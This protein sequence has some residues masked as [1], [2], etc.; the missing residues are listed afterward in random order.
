[1][2]QETAVPTEKKKLEQNLSCLYCSTLQPMLLLLGA[3]SGDVSFLDLRK[4]ASHGNTTPVYSTEVQAGAVFCCFLSLFVQGC[5]F[6]LFFLLLFLFVFAI[7][8]LLFFNIFILVYLFYIQMLS[9]PVSA[10]THFSTSFNSAQVV[11]VGNERGVVTWYISQP[12]QKTYSLLYSDK[13]AHTP[14][15]IVALQVMHFPY[16]VLESK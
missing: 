15:K 13:E 3:E 16:Q 2:L 8:L 6:V 14:Y 12:P 11:V 1:M 7:T 5:C 9:E 10:L 4:G